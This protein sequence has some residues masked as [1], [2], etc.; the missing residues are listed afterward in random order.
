[1]GLDLITVLVVLDIYSPR[2]DHRPVTVVR[3]RIHLAENAA[4]PRDCSRFFSLSHTAVP[5]GTLRICEDIENAGYILNAA[6]WWL[7]VALQSQL[8]K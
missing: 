2:P 7:G 1:M 3:R 6:S 4:D 8:K 5:P